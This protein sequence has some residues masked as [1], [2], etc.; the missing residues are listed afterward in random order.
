MNLAGY[1][2]LPCKRCAPR[3]SP[4]TLKPLNATPYLSSMVMNY[5]CRWSSGNRERVVKTWGLVSDAKD[6]DGAR[7][8]GNVINYYKVV[9]YSIYS[10]KLYYKVP[11]LG[12]LQPAERRPILG[13]KQIGHLRKQ[14][15]A[16]DGLSLRPSKIGRREGTRR[17]E[18]P[19][20]RFFWLLFFGQTKKSNSPRSAMRAYTQSPR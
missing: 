3:W 20:W 14:C 12:P 7:K 5:Q 1:R 6:R 17:A 10:N 11:L 8:S 13:G 18:L 4:K 2:R 19:G 9:P 16:M 15:Q